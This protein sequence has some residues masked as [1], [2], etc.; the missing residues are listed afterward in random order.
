[1]KYLATSLLLLTF[2]GCALSQM[3]IDGRHHRHQDNVQ[4]PSEM[5]SRIIPQQKSK[6]NEKKKITDCFDY[7]GKLKLNTYV[8]TLLIFC[9]SLNIIINI[10]NL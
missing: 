10:L 5:G 1:M 7:K 4:K 6:P 2:V 9:L 3:I 8:Q